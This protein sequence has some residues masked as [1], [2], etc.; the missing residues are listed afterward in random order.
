VDFNGDGVPE[1]AIGRLP[2]TNLDEL[3]VMV[4]KIVTYEQGPT[5]GGNLLVADTGDGFSFEADS[6]NLTGLLPGGI[7]DKIYRSQG[8]SQGQLLAAL[9][10]GY[11]VVN[12]VGH[13]S[14]V[15][16]RGLLNTDQALKLTNGNRLSFVVAMDCMNGRFQN[17]ALLS[18]AEALLCA[19]NGGAVA[20]WA[21]SGMCEPEG[22]T[23]MNQALYQTLFAGKAL[24]SPTM[25][26]GEAAMRAKAGTTDSDVRRTWIFFGDPSTRLH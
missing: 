4:S 25:T 1:M 13:G 14:S 19:P 24:L 6:D 3:N 22:Q 15:V 23:P 20:M 16:W 11:S 5:I 21:S 17:P 10:Q 12:Y 8:G 18:M 26:L 2:A 7:A 9:N